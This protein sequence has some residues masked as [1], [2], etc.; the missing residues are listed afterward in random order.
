VRRKWQTRR[1]LIN[2]NPVHLVSIATEM[3][4]IAEIRR[5]TSESSANDLSF[6]DIIDCTMSGI[7]KMWY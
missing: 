2:A 7:D 6:L 3:R 1:A 4:K 5:Q